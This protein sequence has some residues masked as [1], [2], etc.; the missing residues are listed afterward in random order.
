MLKPYSGK[1][2]NDTAESGEVDNAT[3]LVGQKGYP[4]FPTPCVLSVP[5]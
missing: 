5:R 3:V 2:A 4:E 1:I